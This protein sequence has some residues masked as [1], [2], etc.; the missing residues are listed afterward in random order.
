[1][2]VL[3]MFAVWTSLSVVALLSTGTQAASL[4][5]RL[6]HPALGCVACHGNTTP[7]PGSKVE[8]TT[9]V[10]CHGEM[11]KLPSVSNAFGRD[12]HHSPHYADLMDCTTCHAEHKASRS[13]C[14]DCHVTK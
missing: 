3:K 8:T 2:N 13:L 12:A 14:A 6:V 9:C 7:Q 11:S 5:D 4:P 1:M 10:G